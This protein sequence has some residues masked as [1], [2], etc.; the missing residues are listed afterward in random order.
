MGTQADFQV[1]AMI[2]HIDYEGDGYYS[3][4]GQRSGWVSARAITPPQI[5][6]ESPQ[7]ETYNSSDVTLTYLADEQLN[8]TTYSLDGNE[9]VTFSGNA[10]LTALPN[11]MHNVTVYA[12][13]QAGNVGASETVKFA[14]AVPEPESFPTVTIT[15]SIVVAVVVCIGLLLCVK[16]RRRQTNL[17]KKP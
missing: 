8:Q 11:G 5:S 12:W 9:N 16:I 10:T 4:T 6:I 17:A 1:Q 2:G 15:F 14:I 3:F 7:K 13:D